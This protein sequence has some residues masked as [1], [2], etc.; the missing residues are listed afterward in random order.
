MKSREALQA[1]IRAPSGPILP[2]P[3]DLRVS[4]R[5]LRAGMA[6]ALTYA[7]ADP[8]PGSA[9]PDE[10]PVMSNHKGDSG[11]QGPPPSPDSGARP[12]AADPELW[13]MLRSE[14]LLERV[15]AVAARIDERVRQVSTPGPAGGSS[16]PGAVPEFAAGVAL[17]SKAIGR[18]LRERR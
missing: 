16:F 1:A 12:A 5:C 2:A 8:P 7:V 13:M 18:L 17:V 10:R 9:A 3:V 6:F 11:G 14:E 4:H 15:H